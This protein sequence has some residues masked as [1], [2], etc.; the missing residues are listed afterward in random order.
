M[1]L[2]KVKELVKV[3]ASIGKRPANEVPVV[4]SKMKLPN[5]KPFY[6]LP[7]KGKYMVPEV[8]VINKIIM[9]IEPKDLIETAKKVNFQSGL[10]LITVYTNPKNANNMTVLVY[11]PKGYCCYDAFVESDNPIKDLEDVIGKDIHI[12]ISNDLADYH[13]M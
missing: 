7:T 10:N 8:K 1:K 12:D 3:I 11:T 5:N 9:S 2:K 4:E 6:M 13:I